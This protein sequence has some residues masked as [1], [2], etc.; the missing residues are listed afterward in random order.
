MAVRP[1]DALKIIRDRAKDSGRIV[2]LPH[3][4]ARMRERRIDFL[5]V[6]SCLKGGAITEGPHVPT[7]SRSGANRCN[8]EG[9]V[10]GERLRVVV[11]LPDKPPELLVVTV[12]DLPR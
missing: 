5:D 8:V 6:Q 9:M 10:D 7:D 2:V 11:E 4:R 3:A 1:A 12:I